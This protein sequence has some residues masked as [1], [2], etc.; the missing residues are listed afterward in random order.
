MREFI[1]MHQV[2]IVYLMVLSGGLARDIVSNKDGE[3]SCVGIV[4]KSKI[5]TRQGA[6]FF[7][8]H[9]FYSVL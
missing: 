4:E 1:S 5:L 9:P 8:T 6:I 2:T 3:R 7:R